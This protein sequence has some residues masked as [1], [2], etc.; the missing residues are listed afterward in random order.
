MLVAVRYAVT[1]TVLDTT[2]GFRVT[3]TGKADPFQCT[4]AEENPG[5]ETCN[6]P[7][8]GE[9]RKVKEPASSEIVL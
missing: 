1:T 3:A 5:A 9:D 8:S 2:A 6:V 7:W 4:V